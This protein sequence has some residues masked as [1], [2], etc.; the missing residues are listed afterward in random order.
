LFC[1]YLAY[2]F[3]YWGWERNELFGDVESGYIL[4]PN[5]KAGDPAI[6][7]GSF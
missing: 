7:N 2:Y 1:A 6:E 5:V 4:T 3:W